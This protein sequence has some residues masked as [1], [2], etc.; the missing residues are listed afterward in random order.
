MKNVIAVPVIVVI[1]IGG[2]PFLAIGIM[3]WAALAVINV[4]LGVM[5]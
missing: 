1:A 2:A 4:C 3:V 5:K